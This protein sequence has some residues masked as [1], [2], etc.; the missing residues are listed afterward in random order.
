MKYLILILM[1]VVATG[2]GEDEPVLLE[3]EKMVVAPGLGDIC[4]W[5]EWRGEALYDDPWDSIEF[6]RS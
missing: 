5:S 2:F 6:I 3:V 4:G 1:V